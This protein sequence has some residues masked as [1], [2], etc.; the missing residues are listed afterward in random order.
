MIGLLVIE[1]STGFRNCSSHYQIATLMLPIYPGC[2]PDS[3]NC[4]RL[5]KTNP[6]DKLVGAM[7]ATALLEVVAQFSRHPQPSNEP[8]KYV[9]ISENHART[10]VAIIAVMDK[11]YKRLGLNNVHVKITE[12]IMLF[13]SPLCHGYFHFVTFPAANDISMLQKIKPGQRGFAFT[14]PPSTYQART[15]VG[16]TQ[17]IDGAIGSAICVQCGHPKPTTFDWDRQCLIRSTKVSLRY[18]H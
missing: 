3:P 2:S 14:F 18:N 17:S 6:G 10:P 5:Y 15:R 8:R 12:S 11:Y 4:I 9:Q 7:E 1:I 13:K 16:F